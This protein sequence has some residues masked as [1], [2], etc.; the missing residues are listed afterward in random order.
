MPLFELH[1]EK[2]Q[3]GNTMTKTEFIKAISE[4]T[5]M[6]KGVVDVFLEA[7]TD[8]LQEA[9]LQGED[10]TVSNLG[11][12]TCKTREARM[13]RNPSTGEAMHIPSHKTVTFKIAKNLKD[14]LNHSENHELSTAE[15]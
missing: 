11:K 7:V 4:K 10:V 13:G 1:D 2:T 15:S 6:S 14:T 8:T 3:K 5:C 12:F 9:F